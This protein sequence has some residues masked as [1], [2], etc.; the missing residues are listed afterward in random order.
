MSWCRPC[1]DTSEREKAL[2]DVLQEK[3][4]EEL[5]AVLVEVLVRVAKLSDE[6]A[7]VASCGTDVREAAEEHVVARQH[8]VEAK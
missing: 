6:G 4:E 5:T 3:E 1:T 7:A 8:V 2:E